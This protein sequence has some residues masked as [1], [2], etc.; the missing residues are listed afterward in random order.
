MVSLA[1]LRSQLDHDQSNQ[2]GDKSAGTHKR[3][4]LDYGGHRHMVRPSSRRQL[5]QKPLKIDLLKT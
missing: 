5:P 3:Q 1:S 2:G 4:G